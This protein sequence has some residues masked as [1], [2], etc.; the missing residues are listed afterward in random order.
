MISNSVALTWILLDD[1]YLLFSQSNIS[2]AS[3][4]ALQ[5][6]LK[7]LDIDDQ[8]RERLEQ[9]L[10]QKQTVGELIA[11]DFEKLGELGAGNGGVVTKVSHK[12]SGLIMARKV[13][14]M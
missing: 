10:S 4:E 9:F 6:K 13:R 5:K 8:Q 3:L 2:A 11:E 1:E 12:K 7:E 14:L